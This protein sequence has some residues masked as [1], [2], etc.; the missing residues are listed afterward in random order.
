MSEI[1]DPS[2]P[3]SI[4]GVAKLVGKNNEKL[5]KK[6][7]TALITYAILSTAY[8]LSLGWYR[9]AKAQVVYSTVVEQDDPIYTDLMNWLME[10]IPEPS[11]KSVVA[12]SFQKKDNRGYNINQGGLH[13][14]YDSSR[15]QTVLIDGHKVKVFVEESTANSSDSL[16]LGNND[17]SDVSQA[18]NKALSKSVYQIRL[19]CGGLDSS[20]AVEK[21][22]TQLA[23]E[24][25]K[26]VRNP[27]LWISTRWGSWKSRN[28]LPTRNIDTIVLK[29]G[30]KERLVEDIEQFRADAERYNALGIPY[31]RGYLLAGPP[32]TGKTSIARA[33]ADKFKMDL[34]YIPLGDLG[35]DASLMELV[36]DVTAGSM[37][38][39]EDIDVFS[40]SKDRSS[41]KSAEDSGDIF[42]GIS[43]SGLLNSLDG[44]ATPHGLI[45]VMTSN[46]PDELDPAL[47][48]P[49]RIDLIE[50]ISYTDTEQVKGLF[51]CF[52]NTVPKELDSIKKELSPAYIIEIMKQNFNDPEN[53]LE[54]LLQS[55]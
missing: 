49:G 10:S 46:H 36:S 52:Y 33:L 41:A 20:K 35:A 40:V 31:H 47:I 42:G 43:L 13:L 29:E 45:T 18:L 11:R 54:S 1:A 12:K 51:H 17:S 48:R 44:V 26:V 5:S 9:K 50:Q 21:L 19:E 7:E 25:Y 3:L 39:L 24:H 32:G 30:Q 37:L 34:F 27:V 4:A 55:V 23:E 28:D 38:L 14:F 8:R 2:E 22:L 6:V 53:A 15:A 16:T